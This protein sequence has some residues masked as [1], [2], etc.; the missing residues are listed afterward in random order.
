MKPICGPATR[1]ASE[2]IREAEENLRKL[3]EE[4][5]KNAYDEGF[6]QGYVVG[7]SAG[8]R[9]AEKKAWSDPL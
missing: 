1:P 3:V 8:K 5:R 2:I 9:D 6:G 7:V 4:V